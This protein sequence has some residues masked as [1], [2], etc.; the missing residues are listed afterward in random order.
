[1]EVDRPIIRISPSAWPAGPKRAYNF[2]VDNGEW[3]AK[4]RIRSRRKWAGMNRTISLIS[5]QLE[6][7]NSRQINDSEGTP[8]PSGNLPMRNATT[9]KASAR[10]S[11]VS[12]SRVWEDDRQL[13]GGAGP[14]Q[15]AERAFCSGVGTGL[16]S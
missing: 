5:T 13:F 4:C 12:R 11:G 8:L 16:C 9:P 7:I 1:M 3:T 10:H 14:D 6:R 15:D 2:R